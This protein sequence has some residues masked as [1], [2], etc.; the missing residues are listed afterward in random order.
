[1]NIVSICI[2]E[3]ETYSFYLQKI[4]QQVLILDLEYAINKKIEQDLWNLGFKNYIDALQ[5]LV[6][7]RKVSIFSARTNFCDDMLLI[8]YFHFM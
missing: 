2:V 8:I 3:N 6:K 7:D 1:M 4:Y 5:K